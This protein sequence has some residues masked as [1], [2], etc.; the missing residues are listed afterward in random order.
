MKNSSENLKSF[1][2]CP[3]WDH[4]AYFWA[5]MNFLKILGSQILDFTIIYHH[6][7]T[8]QKKPTIIYQDKLVTDRMKNRQ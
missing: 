6:V 2:I 1:G 5:T 8:K 4:F 7:K 3:F